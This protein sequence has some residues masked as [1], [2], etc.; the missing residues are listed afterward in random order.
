M[1]YSLTYHDGFFDITT[2]GDAEAAPFEQILDDMLRHE[3]WKPGSPY[4]HDHTDFNSGPLTIDDIRNIAYMCE[5]RRDELGEAKCA[6][7]VARDL[8]F[9]LA[10]MWGSL[11]DGKWDVEANV[12][13]T[14]DEAIAWLNE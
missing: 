2:S 5:A 13:R 3:T 6:L 10:R 8:E 14:R 9:G 11:V 12:F 1:E 7:V 4:L